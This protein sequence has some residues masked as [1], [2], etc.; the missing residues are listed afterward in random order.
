[1]D[2][3]G[4]WAPDHCVVG[5]VAGEVTAEEANPEAQTKSTM[6]FAALRT[7]TP[8]MVPEEDVQLMFAP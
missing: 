3:A 4:I 2:G 6:A 7:R 5:M 8:V 1:M